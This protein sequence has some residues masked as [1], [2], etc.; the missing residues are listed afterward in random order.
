MMIDSGVKGL[1]A[2]S[3]G[4]ESDCVASS[5]RKYCRILASTGL[6]SMGSVGKD[7]RDAALVAQRICVLIPG[8]WRRDDLLYL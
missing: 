1:D 4:R 3:G 8:Q 5:S 7:M 2:L 6:E